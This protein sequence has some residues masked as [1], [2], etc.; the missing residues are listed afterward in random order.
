MSRI[1]SSFRIFTKPLSPEHARRCVG[2][3]AADEAPQG[4]FP[5]ATEDNHEAAERQVFLAAHELLQEVVRAICVGVLLT[6]RDKNQLA[7]D[8]FHGL[9]IRDDTRR[10]VHVIWEGTQVVIAREQE[11]GR[12]R[13]QTA[14]VGK[15]AV[16]QLLDGGRL[17]ALEEATGSGQDAF[18]DLLDLLLVVRDRLVRDDLRFGVRE[19]LLVLRAFDEFDLLVRQPVEAVHDFVDERIRAGEVALDGDERC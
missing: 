16:E 2:I 1:S 19:G 17:D 11:R 9:C 14:P 4:S 3:H 7:Q 13:R 10:E 6:E 12:V 18:R 15:L 5:A 8:H